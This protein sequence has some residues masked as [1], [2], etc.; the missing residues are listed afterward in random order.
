MN[1][2]T[3]ITILLENRGIRTLHFKVV[4]NDGGEAS[5]T[6]RAKNMLLPDF[7]VYASNSVPVVNLVFEYT[8]PGMALLTHLVL[9]APANK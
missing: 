3:C 7:T 1:V 4:Y 5:K 6:F 9:K 8:G 2:E